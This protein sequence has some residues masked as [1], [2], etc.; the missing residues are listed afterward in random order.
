[1]DLG[2]NTGKFSFMAADYAECVISLESDEKCVNE[3]ENKIS[4]N[5]ENLYTLVGNITKPSP[6][7]G[8]QNGITES[9]FKRC[10]S[11]VVLGLALIHHLYISNKL[12]FNQIFEIFNLFNGNY[13]IV[14]FIP[15]T[16]NKVKLLIKDKKNNLN[17]YNQD[18]FTKALKVWF[19]IKEIVELNKSKRVLYFLERK[20]P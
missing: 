1:M 18:A 5:N 2:A 11:E 15:I 9:I 7:I 17:N 13:L 4:K 14:E 6:K 16:D 10:N 12:S 20:Y 8:L 3:I 19:E